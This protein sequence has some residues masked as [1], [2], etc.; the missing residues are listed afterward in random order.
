MKKLEVM[1]MN[2][3]SVYAIMAAIAADREIFPLE[4]SLVSKVLLGDHPK[5]G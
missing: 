2:D 4:L 1:Y 5:A 3:N